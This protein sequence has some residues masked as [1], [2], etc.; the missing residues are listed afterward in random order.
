MKILF[1]CFLLLTYFGFSQESRNVELLDNWKNDSILLSYS[2]VR[3]NECW[4]FE[5]NGKEYA[6]LGSTEGTHIFEIS[7]EG[8][9]ILRDFI[10]GRNSSAAVENRDFKTYKNYLYA[11]CD[12]ENSS[13]QIMDLSY[14]PDS[15]HVVYDSE[16][17]IVA[18]KNIFIDKET[19]RLY[20]FSPL[21]KVNNSVYEEALRI[22]SLNDPKNPVLVYSDP[23]DYDKIRDGS[24]YNNLAY[25]HRGNE[26][27][28]MYDFSDLQSVTY[29]Q[30]FD[31]N[32][33]KTWINH[34]GSMSPNR[35]N[36]VYI[37][38]NGG[39]ILRTTRVAENGRLIRGESS[40]FGVA[41]QE[42]SMAN[43]VKID[44]QFAFVAYNSHGF[45]IF[46]YTRSTDQR[47]GY[48]DTYPQ[49]SSSYTDGAYGV[50][51]D[52]PSGRI[53]VS[54]RTNGLFLFDFNREA[55][56]HIQG[57]EYQAYPN[58]ISNGED[59]NFY[60]KPEFN[61]ALDYDFVD[62]QGKVVYSGSVTDFSYIVLPINCKAGNYTLNVRFEINFKFEE[63]G[64]PII[65][66]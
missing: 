28:I 39:A 26:G 58:P 62:Q 66:R 44:N 43:Q 49:E 22:H 25:L 45:Q 27:F 23:H 15:V 18:A 34:Q 11:V 32:Q 31:T 61:G 17:E 53:L 51:S 29:K 3:Y 40:G 9:L 41:L 14:L 54:D 6:V 1:T 16:N 7:S 37:D 12:E 57:Y 35:K 38:A 59:L 60:L 64:V 42:G 55:L 50:Y 20:S 36:Y 10:K 5:T 30:A 19:N 2:N 8:K 21:I 65:V 46:D 33:N 48:Y 56:S 47:V 24:V 13:L 63:V 52:L 4:G